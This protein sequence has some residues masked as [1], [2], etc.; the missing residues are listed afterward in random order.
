MAIK[1]TISS[2]VVFLFALSVFILGRNFGGG[3][4]VFPRALAVI[5]MV[6]SVIMF[7]RSIAWPQAVPLGIAKLTRTEAWTTGI[8]VALTTAYIALIVPLGFVAASVLFIATNLEGSKN[9]W[10]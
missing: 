6:I 4:E 2:I 10:L 9:L 8:C 7:V 1:D 3:G 5:M